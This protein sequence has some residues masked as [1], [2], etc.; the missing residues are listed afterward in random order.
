MNINRLIIFHGEIVNGFGGAERV[1]FELI[2][3]FKKRNIDVILCTFNLEIEK[4]HHYKYYEE[5]KTNL[6][7]IDGGSRISKVLNFRKKISQF[8][9]DL[10]VGIYGGILYL[11]TLLFNIPYVTIIHGTMFWSSADVTKYSFLHKNVFDEILSEGNDHMEFISRKPNISVLDRIIMEIKAIIDY[12]GVKKSE[13]ILVVTERVGWEVK[14]LYGKDSLLVKGSIDGS[15]VGHKPGIDIRKLHRLNNDD[16]I[17]LSI[18]R[19]GKRK[20]ID[21]LIKSFALL[22]QKRDD[23]KL[24]IIGDGDSKQELKELAK[25]LG[26]YASVFFIDFISDDLLWD[27][28]HYCDVFAFP[29]WTSKGLTLF[30]ALAM[31]KKIVLSSE[32]FSGRFPETISKSNYLFLSNPNE[33]S[34]MQT[35][36]EALERTI[37]DDIDLTEFFWDN[38]FESAFTEIEIWFNGVT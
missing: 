7:K 31:K 32:G 8:N 1:A 38:S 14:K 4:L 10:I 9:P 21:L 11:S 20:R 13:S 3:F 28:Y 22:C 5:I 27:Y 17:I 33:I 23:V 12:I 18:S 24:F 25:R 6:V 37:I 29:G 34:F 26:C 30:E 36:N 16:H 19:L 15:I 35:I 2:R